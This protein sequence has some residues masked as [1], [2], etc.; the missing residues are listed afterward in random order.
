[1]SFSRFG[2]G[3]NEAD[4]QG[5]NI[6][7]EQVDALTQFAAI[8]S[9]LVLYPVEQQD[10]LANT[11]KVPILSNRQG[12]TLKRSRIADQD[13]LGGG[14]VF[15]PDAVDSR[16]VF[17][18]RSRDLYQNG[19]Q[20][21]LALDGSGNVYA[22]SDTKLI[23]DKGEPGEP[24][25]PGPP[26]QGGLPGKEGLPGLDGAPGVQG[27]KGEQGVPGPAGEKGERGE[28]GAEGTIGQDFSCTNLT[29]GPKGGRVYE[30]NNPDGSFGTERYRTISSS[31][32]LA[33][34][35]IS[36]ADAHLGQLWLNGSIQQDWGLNGSAGAVI[37]RIATRELILFKDPLLATGGTA[38][39]RVDGPSNVQRLT[40]T[41]L[42]ASTVAAINV[43]SRLYERSTSVY[44]QNNIPRDV[45]VSIK[46]PFA[47]FVNPDSSPTWTTA[48]GEVYRLR[49][50]H[51]I[52][53]SAASQLDFKVYLYTYY[54]I[55]DDTY[56]GDFAKVP[57]ALA[58]A[59][60]YFVDLDVEFQ[61]FS[62]DGTPRNH[63]AYVSHSAKITCHSKA[64]NNFVSSQISSQVFSE[65]QRLWDMWYEFG[66]P[67]SS[68]NVMSP[69]ILF[70][71][72][73]GSGQ[74]DM[75]RILYYFKRVA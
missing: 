53:V 74:I 16:I 27:A 52:T 19:G 36:Y 26:G 1:M 60:T 45:V 40:C 3:D 25:P 24:G 75:K 64:R 31:S 28:P 9:Q 59:G 5:L 63:K 39:L 54:Y 21:V 10:N 70:T 29:V 50:S 56:V 48:V 23:G 33:P 30:T 20:N 65:P 61:V 22:L 51:Q 58:S 47:S 66:A 72:S 15:F 42:V 2:Y 8:E 41:A 38:S 73:L 17:T 13:D 71:V 67:I 18:E 34:A 43:P 68:P 44:E 49:S 37:N 69:D 12:R 55:F 32:E 7:Q 14:I 57:L 35:L 62:W 11:L 46:G 6:T 4:L